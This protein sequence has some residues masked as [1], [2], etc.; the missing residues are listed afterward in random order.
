MSD[1]ASVLAG[2]S[3]TK[4]VVV[5]LSSSQCEAVPGPTAGALLHD[6][7]EAAGIHIAALAALLK[8]PEQRLEALEQDR[9]DLLLDAVFARALASSVCRTLKIDAAP[10]L[11]RLPPTSAYR[12]KYPS[13]GINTPFRPLGD[14]PGPSVW[15]QISRPIVLAG[16]TLLLGALVLIFL[17][18]MKQDGAPE[19][20]DADGS[21]VNSEPLALLP[22]ASAGAD[23]TDSASAP[24]SV[25]AAQ[26]GEAVVAASAAAT[27][28]PSSTAGPR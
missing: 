27:A 16:L 25:S 4:A 28:S 8:V 9:L 3:N 15:P 2:H 7:R 12:L 26:T 13:A 20:L 11:E 5:D 22:V 23:L 6:A 19:K 1:L 14:S 21:L 17:P 24:V 18:A 10:V